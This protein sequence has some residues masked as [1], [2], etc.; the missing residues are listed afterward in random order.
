MSLQQD[1]QDISDAE[2]ALQ[3]LGVDS[4]KYA[5]ILQQLIK[6]RNAQQDMQKIQQNQF[7][8]DAYNLISQVQNAVQSDKVVVLSQFLRTFAEYVVVKALILQETYHDAKTIVDHISPMGG[9][10]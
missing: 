9:T 3:V 5:Q 10:A 1:Q 2:A 8:A 4:A 7:H 6:R